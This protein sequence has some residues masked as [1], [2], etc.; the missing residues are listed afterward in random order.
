VVGVSRPLPKRFI[1]TRQRALEAPEEG[2]IAWRG[3]VQLP[4][5][6]SVQELLQG[7]SG[8]REN[9]SGWWATSGHEPIMSPSGWRK[10]ERSEPAGHADPRTTRRYDRACH[11]LDRHPTY[12]LAG[13]VT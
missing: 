10:W 1:P 4:R 8:L 3:D 13:L 11:N 2:D 7:G 5:L 9:C 6:D 12:A